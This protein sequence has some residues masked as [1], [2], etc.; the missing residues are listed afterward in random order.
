[1]DNKWK[2]RF[3]DV[4]VQA[5]T[6]SRD[7]S[8]KVGAILVDP[9]SNTIE[10]TGFNGF[11]RGVEDSDERYNDRPT[12]YA[13]VV[14]AELNAVIQAGK[15]ARGAWMF[16]TLFPCS[17]CAKAIIQSGVER[18]LVPHNVKPRRWRESQ[19]IATIMF[20]EAGI[21]VEFVYSEG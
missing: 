3:I 1:M 20:E 2:N 4:A 11:P 18:I 14:H 8:T 5:S 12:K 6:W 9:L 7:P 13:M 19:D 15:E 17:E 16:C 10:A 21:A